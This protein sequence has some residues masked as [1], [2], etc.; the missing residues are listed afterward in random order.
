MTSHEIAMYKGGRAAH[1]DGVPR[2]L[3][4]RLPISSTDRALALKGWDK[5]AAETADI[6]LELVT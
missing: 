1:D 6:E 3:L 2:M 4:V 5:R